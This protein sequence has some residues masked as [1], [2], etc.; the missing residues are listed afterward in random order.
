MLFTKMIKFDCNSLRC[1]M[2]GT[3]EDVESAETVLE[4]VDLDRTK[5][6]EFLAKELLSKGK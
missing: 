2:D 3:V 1:N 5:I 4:K 6:P